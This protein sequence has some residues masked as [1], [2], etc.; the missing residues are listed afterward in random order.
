[1]PR[2]FV[3][4][5]YS[6]DYDMENVAGRVHF[7]PGGDAVT[8]LDVNERSYRPSVNSNIKVTPRLFS[9]YFNQSVQSLI[10]LNSRPAFFLSLSR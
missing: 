3:V 2:E 4:H 6:P 8:T 1:M 10:L 9:G 5:G 7:G